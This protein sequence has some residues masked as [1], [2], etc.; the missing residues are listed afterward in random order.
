MRIKNF[1]IVGILFAIFVLPIACQRYL[2]T[3][4]KPKGITTPNGGVVSTLAGSAGVS[5]FANGTGTAAAFCGPAGLGVDS[6]GNVYVADTNDDLIR[7]ITPGGV[8]STLAGTLTVCGSIN[9]TGPSAS[10]CGPLGVAV[11]SSGN[12]YVADTWNYLVREITSGGVVS[13]LAGSAGV[14]GATNGTGTGASFFVPTGVAVDSSGN[15]YIADMDNQLIRKIF[16]GGVVT[17]LAGSAGVTGATNGT[18]TAALFC[19]PSGVAVDSSGNVYVADSGNNLIRE[20]TPG[21]VVSTL[22]GSA[23][24]TGATNGTGNGALFYGPSGV[25][26]DSSGN[27]YVADSGNNLIREITPGGVVSTLAGSGSIGSSNGTG[28]AASFSNPYGI[29]VGSSGIV[30]VSDACLIREIQ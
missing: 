8:V 3:A 30:Y 17:T 14:T 4:P 2:P 23:G 26:V 22:A 1:R 24:V 20:I 25:A 19:Y 7:E 15:L 6:S 18:G 28:T 27:V 29:A 9:G 13:T 21:G 16:P 10:F 5:A 11:D 12:I